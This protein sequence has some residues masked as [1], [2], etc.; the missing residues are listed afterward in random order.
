MSELEVLEMST[1]LGLF[2]SCP[3]CPN[4]APPPAVA[5][6]NSETSKCYAFLL[7]M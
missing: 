4:A 6:Y 2:P 1:V 5:A 7:V 3:D